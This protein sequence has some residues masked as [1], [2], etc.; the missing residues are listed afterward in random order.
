MMPAVVAWAVFFI[1][2]VIVLGADVA[3]MTGEAI[4]GHPGGPS[5]LLLLGLVFLAVWLWLI[6]GFR[7]GF[8]VRPESTAYP[9]DDPRSMF[10]PHMVREDA[11]GFPRPS[12]SSL[13]IVG[14]GVL[15]VCVLGLLAVGLAVIA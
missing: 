3:R 7:A 11:G 9:E 10:G 2:A 4:A 12:A 6:G 15:G 8:W 1:P 5:G 13:I 14:V